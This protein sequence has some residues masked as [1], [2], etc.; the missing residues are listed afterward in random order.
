MASEIVLR[1]ADQ[2]APGFPSLKTLSTSLIAELVKCRPVDRM[3]V[4]ERQLA[5]F[6]I[7]RELFWSYVLCH[8]LIKFEFLLGQG[9][10]KRGY[11]LEETPNNPRD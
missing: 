5:A 2:F 7:F 6:D 11:Q 8:V 10:D 9:V 1:F 3:V 4:L